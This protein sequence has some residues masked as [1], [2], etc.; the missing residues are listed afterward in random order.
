MSVPVSNMKP[1]TDLTPYGDNL[2]AIAGVC[3]SHS[4]ELVFMTQPTTWNS[5]VDPKT[6]EW[7]WLLYRNGV[8][9]RADLMSEALEF[10]NDGTRQVADEN[11]VPTYDLATL[12]P[13]SLDYFYDDV[14][15][16]TKGAYETGK[17]LA[18]FILEKGL[19]SN[20]TEHVP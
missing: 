3:K 9:Y 11:S 14:H 20:I 4:I 18:S 19:I 17:G 16:N 10:Y 12:L 7:Q 1:R 6:E 2:G 13:K 15:F 5:S 8:T